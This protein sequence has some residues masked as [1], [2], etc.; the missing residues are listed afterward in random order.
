M[1][2]SSSVLIVI[3]PSTPS[4]LLRDCVELGD[5]VGQ[6]FSTLKDFVC[7]LSALERRKSSGRKRKRASPVLSKTKSLGRDEGVERSKD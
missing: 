1:F 7:Q 2:R 3:S 4:A 6:P 5:F